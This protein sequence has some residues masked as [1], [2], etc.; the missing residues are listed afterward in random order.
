[1]SDGLIGTAIGVGLGI[2]LYEEVIGKKKRKNS[3]KKTHKTLWDEVK[4]S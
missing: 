1:M 3:R 4:N 2:Y